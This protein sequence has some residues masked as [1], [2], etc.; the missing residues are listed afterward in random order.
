[1]RRLVRAVTSDFKLGVLD[2]TEIDVDHDAGYQRMVG[3]VA[4]LVLEALA[5]VRRRQS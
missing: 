5:D 4:S 2:I 1:M 3:L